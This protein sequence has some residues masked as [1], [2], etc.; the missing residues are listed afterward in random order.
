[1]KK[2]TILKIGIAGGIYNVLSLLFISIS[3]QTKINF[4]GKFIMMYL[5]R[6]G[7]IGYN[8][9]ILG[10]LIGCF[11]VFLGGLFQFGLIALIF[12]IINS[13]KSLSRW[14]KDRD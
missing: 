5:Q 12:D 7:V 8:L 4:F 6:Y 13:N 9:S 1:M 14:F 10:T 3:A 2:I 11:W